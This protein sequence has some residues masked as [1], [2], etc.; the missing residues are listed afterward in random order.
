MALPGTGPSFQKNPVAVVQGLLPGSSGSDWHN[1]FFLASRYGLDGLELVFDGDIASNPLMSGPGL[2]MIRR[3]STET[4]VRVLSVYASFFL[5]FPLHKAH[6]DTDSILPVLNKLLN[7][8]AKVGASQLVL[9][10]YGEAGIGSQSEERALKKALVS[11]MGEAIT[12]GVNLSLLSD[13]P[14][15]RLLVFMREFDSPAITAVF[16]AAERNVTDPQ[17]E[18]SIYGQYIS[19]VHVR[20][21]TAGGEPASLGQGIV[22]LSLICHKLKDQGYSGPFILSGRADGNEA[23]LKDLKHMRSLLA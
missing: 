8:C 17:R 10:C 9:P 19:S 7:A 6:S 20:D 4:G 12:C 15:E 21:R 1:E 13:L 16:D 18:I 2:D 3:V 14:A 11:C 22:E 23:F 5:Q